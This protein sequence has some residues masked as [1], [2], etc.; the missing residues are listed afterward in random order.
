MSRHGPHRI[1]HDHKHQSRGDFERNAESKG[2]G[3]VLSDDGSDTLVG[4]SKGSNFGSKKSSKSKNGPPKFP[5][6]D[7]YAPKSALITD[8]IKEHRPRR[9]LRWCILLLLAVIAIPLLVIK[10]QS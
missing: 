1:S 6:D 3:G 4:S 9:R 8:S 5:K 2:G 10:V 7:D